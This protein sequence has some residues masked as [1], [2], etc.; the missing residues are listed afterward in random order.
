MILQHMPPK[1]CFNSQVQ[2]W[3]K[4]TLT[5]EKKTRLENNWTRKKLHKHKTRLKKARLEENQTTEK[6]G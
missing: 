4:I 6:L 1:G 2:E 3:E 5:S